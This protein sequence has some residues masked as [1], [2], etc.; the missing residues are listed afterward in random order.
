MEYKDLLKMTDDAL[1]KVVRQRRDEFNLAVAALTE[2]Q[3]MQVIINALNGLARP[4][5][6]ILVTK[7]L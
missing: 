2:R 4:R 7:T 3:G 1:M 5:V 6:D